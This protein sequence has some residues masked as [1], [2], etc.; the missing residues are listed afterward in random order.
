MIKAIIFDLDGT[1]V[2][3]EILKAQ[4]YAR[5]A[6]QLTNSGLQESDVL[7]A[8]GHIVGRSRQEVAIYLLERFGFENAAGKQME[9]LGVR[10]LF[11]CDYVSTIKCLRL[12]KYCF[13]IAALTIWPYCGKCEKGATPRDWRPCPIASKPKRC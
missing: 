11:S 5:A 8:F 2:Q 13:L 9:A 4:S 1:L 3:T 6:V 12:L 10:R 7:A